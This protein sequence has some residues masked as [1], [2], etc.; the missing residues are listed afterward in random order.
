M[1]VLL[2]YLLMSGSHAADSGASGTFALLCIG[3]A[4]VAEEWGWPGGFPHWRASRV[5]R[6]A[7]GRMR[8][9]LEAGGLTVL[10][11]ALA[12]LHRYPEAAAVLAG[13]L[14]ADLFTHLPWGR[15]YS[16]GCLTAAALFPAAILALAPA[17]DSVSPWWALLGVGVIAVSWLVAKGAGR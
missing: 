17:A 2:V 13:L 4:H 1:E 14:F 5:G 10:L 8:V 15:V 9:S 11:V 3:L 6:K 12:A 16:P 7:P